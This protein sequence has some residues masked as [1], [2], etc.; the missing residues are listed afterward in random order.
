MRLKFVPVCGR[1]NGK[2]YKAITE[3]LFKVHKNSCP[4]LLCR[5]RNAII[6]QTM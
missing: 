5:I 3:K 2:I 1:K 4:I 6:K